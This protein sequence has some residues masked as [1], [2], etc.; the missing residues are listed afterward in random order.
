[1]QAHVSGKG[2]TEPSN[3]VWASIGFF[4][5]VGTGFVYLIGGLL[6]VPWHWLIPLWAGWLVGLWGTY[7]LERRRSWWVLAAAPIV[8]VV[9]WVYLEAGWDMWDWAVEDLPLGGR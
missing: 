6:F 7:R 8:L 5:Y 9:L 3:R 2:E 4:V 1:V